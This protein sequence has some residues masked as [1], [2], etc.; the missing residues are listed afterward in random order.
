MLVPFRSFAF[1]KM[2]CLS[3]NRK[4]L[5]TIVLGLL[6]LFLPALCVIIL[7]TVSVIQITM[8]MFSETFTDI[9]IIR[10]NDQH[11]NVTE[12]VLNVPDLI[13]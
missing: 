5:Q 9:L 2:F 10:K 7:H 12:Y 8:V 6:L 3:L 11:V 1:L 13:V 4:S